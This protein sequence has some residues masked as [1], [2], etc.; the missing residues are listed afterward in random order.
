MSG[1]KAAAQQ[2]IV[3]AGDYGLAAITLSKSHYDPIKCSPE[4][5]RLL[6]TT[7]SKIV[8]GPVKPEVALG[9]NTEV[10]YTPPCIKGGVDPSMICEILPGDGAKWRVEAKREN[11]VAVMQARDGATLNRAAVIHASTAQYNVYFLD[12][13]EAQPISPGDI[14]LIYKRYESSTGKLPRLVMA[15]VF[16][17]AQELCTRLADYYW[18]RILS[19]THNSLLQTWKILVGQY[20]SR[21]GSFPPK[22]VVEAGKPLP[23]Q[24]DRTQS[25]ATYYNGLM[26]VV[27]TPVFDTAAIRPPPASAAP[28]PVSAASAVVGTASAASDVGPRPS[29]IPAAPTAAAVISAPAVGGSNAPACAGATSRSGCALW[30]RGRLLRRGRGM[31]ETPSE[32]VL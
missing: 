16:S 10:V 3:S 26:R 23:A 1:G 6:F 5:R 15:L 2:R 17:H 30:R 4:T 8:V 22:K 18:L 27:A 24:V 32:T 29:A 9:K 28:R 20:S 31:L 7:E 21:P 13:G 11:A 12:L 25:N 14:V 19:H